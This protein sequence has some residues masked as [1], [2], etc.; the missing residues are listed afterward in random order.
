MSQVLIGRENVIIFLHRHT[1]WCPSGVE[2]HRRGLPAGWSR[3]GAPSSSSDRGAR[4]VLPADL[5][6]PPAQPGGLRGEEGQGGLVVVQKHGDAVH[7]NPPAVTHTRDGLPETSPSHGR[8]QVL[9]L[10][11]ADIEDRREELRP[12]DFP[13]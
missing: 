6:G 7:I 13:G 9:P 2:T 5:E 12:G 11:A 3:D 4:L 8:H 1:P 10:R